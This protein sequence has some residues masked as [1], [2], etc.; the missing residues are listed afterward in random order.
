[1]AIFI[2]RQHRRATLTI[3]YHAVR[4][5]ELR[6][7]SFTFRGPIIVPFKPIARLRYMTLDG[8]A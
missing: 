4:L 2:S 5:E 3:P 8:K 6:L 7:M 1:M